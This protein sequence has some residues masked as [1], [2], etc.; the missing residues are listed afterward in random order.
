MYCINNIFHRPCYF[1][2]VYFE[3]KIGL[4]FF[5]NKFHRS[6]FNFIYK[7]KIKF[8]LQSTY[9]SN[10]QYGCETSNTYGVVFLEY[11]YLKISSIRW[12]A[13]KIR[14]NNKCMRCA[15]STRHYNFFFCVS[16]LVKHNFFAIT[17]CLYYGK[18]KRRRRWYGC[19]NNNVFVY[20]IHWKNMHP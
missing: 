18:K 17:F 10:V 20:E 8:C 7:K 6:V 11:K 9:T 13:Q 19:I 12:Y 4:E 14:Y 16:C 1:K 15:G 3:L 5:I 2:N